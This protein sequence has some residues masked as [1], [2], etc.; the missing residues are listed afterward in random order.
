MLADRLQQAGIGSANANIDFFAPGQTVFSVPPVNENVLSRWEQLAISPQVH[1]GR[2]LTGVDIEKQT[3]YFINKDQIA[4]S[5]DYDFLHVV[6]PMYAPDAV[7]N[8]PLVVPEGKQKGWL[9][10]DK[11]T[12]QHT[13]YPNVFGLGDING[14]PRGKTAAT[15]KKSAPIMANNL[16]Q[17]V[18]GKPVSPLF[19]GYTSCPLLI[20]E[21]SALLVEFN[22]AGEM[23]PTIPG[24]EPLTDSYLAWF[25]E[26][27]MLKPAYMAVL[28]GRVSYLLK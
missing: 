18:Q 28:K 17:A 16:V 7:L 5:E 22:G 11:E 20:R 9:A 3:A 4:Q 8:S 26:D 24:V 27:V 2:T 6:P 23:T 21:G 15:V 12:L 14:T 25:I 1:Y 19:D 13:R 10:V